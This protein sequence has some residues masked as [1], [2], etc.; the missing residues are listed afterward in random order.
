MSK[1]N[2]E[3]ITLD[4]PGIT[5]FAG[6]RNL[7]LKKAKS[8]WVFFVDSDE[9]VT[10]KLRRE[11]EDA[12]KSSDFDGFYVKRKNYFLGK[13][14]G[15]DKILRLGRKNAGEWQRSVHEVWNIKGRTGVL[16]NP[17][18]HNTAVSLNDYIAKINKYAL[19]HAEANK[20]EGKRSNLFKIV[21]YPKLK[22]LQSLLM[23]RGVVFS[24]LQSF[25]SFLAWSNL[26]LSQK[27]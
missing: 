14:V 2:L 15:T 10:K 4:K 8:D 25:H 27:N 5:D 6:E 12:V 21:F 7:L 23:G 17:L 22:F 19:L 20:K 16:K 1:N 24:I 11:I 13:N 18:I 3:I 26:W 9:T